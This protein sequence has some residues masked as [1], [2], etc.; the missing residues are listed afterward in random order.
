[1]A[2]ITPLLTEFPKNGMAWRIDGLGRLIYPGSS[3]SD[4]LIEVFLSELHSEFSDALANK[5]PT[6]KGAV[7]HVKVGKLALLKYGSVWQDQLRIPPKVP[8][9]TAEFI[10]ESSFLQLCHYD[11]SIS[12]DN[13]D[14]QML[15]LHRFFMSG[16]SQKGLVDSWIAVAKHPTP[17][18]EF[19]VIPCAVLFQACL[20]TSPNAIR[21]LAW[22]ELNRVVDSPK[23]I[24]TGPKAKVLYV[25]VFKNIDSDEA[26][27][28]ANLYVDP[29]G[30]REFNRFRNKLIVNSVNPTS[31]K[32]SQPHPT[33][34]H[35]GLPFSNP[36]H[37]QVQGKY[38]PIGTHE[39]GKK[40]WGLLVTQ[41]TSMRTKLVFDYLVTHRKNDSR[42]GANSDDD[43]LKEIN[44]PAPGSNPME[45]EDGEQIPTHSD[46]D[47]LASLNALCIEESGGFLA[48][49]LELIKDPKVTQEY[50][51]KK[52]KPLEGE[53]DGT[54]T[55]GDTREGTSGAAGLDINAAPTPSNPITLMAF[56]ETLELLRQQGY[57]LE[58]VAVATIT[59][60]IHRT[61]IVNFL[62]RKISGVRSWHFMSDAANAP[63]R[64]YIV[65]RHQFG[66]IWHHFI[67]LERKGEEKHS[68]AHIRRVDGHLIEE[69]Q[70]ALFM[71]EVA[72]CGGWSACSAYPQWNVDRIKHSPKQGIARFAKSILN[73]LGVSVIAEGT[74]SSDPA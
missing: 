72:R 47:P 18:I 13:E 59:S 55:T 43:D 19:A 14:V 29:R 49:G 3:R 15:N 22:G 5:S 64:G 12:I 7:A 69:R 28:H 33:F 36:A 16:V 1:M 44:W 9:K 57:E 48:E 46:E 2:L 30:R 32:R 27:A 68:L 39:N 38:L 61:D 65:A 11:A 53:F 52:G 10:L 26:Y 25:E 54:G 35:F 37:L 6:G 17:D 60:P 45:P 56:V 34:I 50:K 23:W 20:A 67:E 66:G 31:G 40:R 8:P 41:V 70:I 62:P 51:R 21:R 4:P 74:K 24:S 58:T 63:P 73:A 71:L 42:Q